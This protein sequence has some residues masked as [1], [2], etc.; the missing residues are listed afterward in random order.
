MDVEL[1]DLGRALE[2]VTEERAGVADS[3]GGVVVAADVPHAVGAFGRCV[4]L[5]DGVDGEALFKEVPH[6]RAEAVAEGEAHFV[7]FVLRGGRDGDEVTE[8]FA[9]ILD[10]GC[11]V[12]ADV[13]PEGAGREPVSERDRCGGS[14]SRTKAEERSGAVVEGHSGVVDIGACELQ[15]AGGE[16]AC[17]S[18]AGPGDDGGLGKT[19]RAACIDEE[20][21]IGRFDSPAN[22]VV[23]PEWL[24]RTYGGFGR[25]GE[26]VYRDFAV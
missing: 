11:V 14:Y 23:F 10:D 24:E 20:A 26:E 6:V 22:S 17:P 1:H 9:D 15:E 5:D 2:E 8:C 21:T 13:P 7:V 3:A 12:G 4:E 18:D 25:G 16:G 19:S